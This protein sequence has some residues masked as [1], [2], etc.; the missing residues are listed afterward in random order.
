MPKNLPPNLSGAYGANRES[1][2][3]VK[4][5][6]QV[7]NDVAAVDQWLDAA[8]NP[9]TK[10]SYTKEAYRFMLWSITF[11]QKPISSLSVEDVQNFEAW[12]ANPEIP[13]TWPKQWRVI[14]P[15]GL[16]T[17]SLK[18]T[19][20]ILHTMFEWLIDA[21]YLSGNPFRLISY[22][23]VQRAI[24]NDSQRGVQRF[25]D[26]EIW[27]WLLSFPDN[28]PVAALE[29]QEQEKAEAELTTRTG[30]EKK[31][32]E[33]VWRDLWP[34]ERRERIR[35]ALVWLYRT[36][37]RRA[38]LA[39]GFAGDVSRNSKGDWIWWVVGKGEEQKDIVLDDEAMDALA[40]YRRSL[41][42]PAYPMV[43]ERNP[44][45]FTLDGAGRESDAGIYRELKAFFKEAK[46]HIERHEPEK[47]VWLPKIAMASTHWLRHSRASH[48][49]LW[50]ASPKSV[51]DQLRHSLPATTAKYYIHQSQSARAEDIAAADRNSKLKAQN[52]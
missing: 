42:R 23:N 4:N 20:R 45:L 38:E 51:Q 13:A 6:L 19:M 3:H 48:L 31:K 10:R 17:S 27:E 39:N 2:P 47:E 36:A 12:I 41:A 49:A 26:P 34:I 25:L 44:L 16:K 5:Q 29:R 40:R 24:D 28:L 22:G 18:Q 43:G 32:R 8:K 1:N 46:S 14:N 30:K 11:Q 7:D 33:R 21:G 9:N 37:V 52:A 50:G 15:R 35:F